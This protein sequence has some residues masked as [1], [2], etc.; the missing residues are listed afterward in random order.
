MPLTALKH[1]MS[2]EDWY[3]NNPSWNINY[4]DPGLEP[5]KISKK[6]L[7]DGDRDSFVVLL[8]IPNFMADPIK[9]GV[10]KNQNVV[11]VNDPAQADYVLYLNYIR[12]SRAHFDFTWC[13][14][15]GRTYNPVLK[16]EFINRVAKTRSPVL[17]TAELNTIIPQLAA[18]PNEFIRETGNH[19]LNFVPGR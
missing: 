13:H 8:P 14:Y 10:R 19:W 6:I 7:N 4:N 12:G 9:A 17:S 15:M 18:F 2:Y 16:L 1:Y 3:H 11:L 5:E